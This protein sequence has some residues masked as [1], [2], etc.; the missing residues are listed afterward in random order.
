MSSLRLAPAPAVESSPTS[1]LGSRSGP[2]LV[3]RIGPR[4]VAVLA[5][6]TGAVVAVYRLRDWNRRRMLA[7]EEKKKARAKEW[8]KIV[9]AQFK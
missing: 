4:E 8:A 9:S 3:V 6:M 7:A 1:L 5:A 2:Q